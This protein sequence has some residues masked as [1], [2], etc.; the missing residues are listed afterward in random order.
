MFSKRLRE[1][2]ESRNMYQ[3]ELAAELN[4]TMQTI[5]G[6]EINRTTPDYET[7]VKIANFFDVSTDFLLGNEEK[8]TNLEIELKEKEA[9]KKLL[10]ENGYLTENE[11]LTKE[12]LK[13]LIEFI[14]IN[15]R[16]IKAVK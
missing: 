10:I 12:E 11:E 6:W 16:Y 4:V 9:L 8:A 5:S 2:R 14:K 15:K 7:L 1:L 3:K 13:N